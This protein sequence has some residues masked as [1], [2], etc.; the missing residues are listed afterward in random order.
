ME[1]P[2]TLDYI[3]PTIEKYHTIDDLLKNKR[4][5]DLWGM[6]KAISIE[7]VLEESF[8]CVVGEPGV[9]KSRFLKE[10]EQKI[11]ARHQHIKASKVERN[12]F[13]TDIEYCIID[14]LDEV[15][16]ESFYNILEEIKHYKEKNSTIK[17][18]FSCR[19]HY[20]ASY[21]RYFSNCKDL[22]FIEICKLN[23][24]D[25][26]KVVEAQYSETTVQNL[27]KNKKLK[28]LI[29]IPRYLTFLLEY[30]QQDCPKI[31]DLFEHIISSSIKDALKCRN[32]ISNKKNI[33]ILIE[34]VLEK[35]A[36]IM[37]ISRKDQISKDELY[38]ILDGIKGNM[39]QMLIANFDLLFFENRILKLT[40]DQLQFEN[41]ELQEYLSA[42]ELCRQDNIE[43]I[44]YD[45]AVNKEL[46]HIYTNWYDVI[47]HIAYT[48]NGI[49]TFINV[50]K[51]I[52]SY[53]SNLENSSFETLLKY[54]DPYLLSLKEKEELFTILFERY[55]QKPTYINWRGAICDLLQQCYTSNCD[56]LLMLDYNQ[57]NKIQ[58]HNI[59]TIL[60]EIIEDHTLSKSLTNHLTKAAS[61][62]I[63]NKD[64]DKQ[65]A[66]LNFYYTL[67]SVESLTQL[68][69]SYHDFN[70]EVKEKYC[71]VSGY[72]KITDKA[73]VDCW[74][75][76][77]YTSN[78]YAINAIINIKD[79]S[80]LMYAYGNLI[81]KNKLDNFFNS[82]GTLAV[83]YEI[84]IKHQFGIA[85]KGD[86]ESRELIT[87]IISNFVTQHLYTNL[88]EIFPLV[89][90]ILLDKLAGKL[91]IE[92]FNNPWDLEDI[93]RRFDTNL[94]DAE[95]I[96]A[97]DKHLSNIN[98]CQ[99]YK[100]SMLIT[101]TSKI[102]NIEN[103]KDSISEYIKR[104]DKT[105]EQ[106]DKEATKIEKNNVEEQN[107][108]LTKYYESLTDP[109]VTNAYKYEAAYALTTN[110]Q[111]VREKGSEA[112]ITVIKTF[113]SELDLD[114]LQFKRETLTSYTI[115]R[116]IV[117]IPVFVQALS[118]LGYSD[119]LTPYRII[120]AKTLPNIY[121][122]NNY[123]K[124][125]I[126]TTYKSVIGE[127]STEEKKMLVEWWKS[128]DDDFM[129][130]SSDDICSCITEY[131]IDELYYKLDEYIE[132]YIAHQ[133]FEHGLDASKA[134]NV[135][136]N[137]KFGWDI[138]KYKSLFNSLK[139]ESVT[140]IK[141]QCNAIM[142]EKFQDPDAISWRIEF[143]KKNTVKS[144]ND[145]EC[146]RILSNEEAEITS[147]N[148]FMFR[149][150]MNIHNKDLERQMLHLFDYGLELCSNPEMQEY[151]SYLLSQTY[152][153]FINLNN[154]Y[155]FSELRNKVEIHNTTHLSYLAT[156]IMHNSETLYLN[157]SHISI[158]EAIKLYNKCIQESYLNIRN[159]EDLR[160]YFTKIQAE[161]QKEIQDQ[162]IYTLVRPEALSEDFIQRE[163]KNTIINKCCQIGLNAVQIDREVALQDN[164]RTDL[165]I[166]YGLCNPIMIELKL[167]HNKEIRN[168]KERLAYKKKFI[169]YTKATNACLSVFWVFDVHREGSDHSKFE[170][171]V[172]EYKDLCNT[173]VYLTDCKSSSI[174]T[175]LPIKKET[176]KQKTQQKKT[177]KKKK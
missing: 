93:F 119:L 176:S 52:L 30:H 44:L 80:T 113:F 68:S 18:I 116:S 29:R 10:M 109:K 47:P 157:K 50:F 54:V 20:V 14:A 101:L 168:S 62:L 108:R 86:S 97:I 107:Q 110:I 55:Q 24:T 49:H 42:K 77:S 21:A 48:E 136:S 94:V 34:R 125:D 67:N 146:M 69:H 128:R 171:L 147:T 17:V 112:L 13:A 123:D 2:M 162:G 16:G 45:I 139:D 172:T 38:T 1:T 9:G 23:E 39:T 56:K 89:K 88:N 43:S 129:N 158:S 167:L 81:K 164:K 60:E 35:V 90:I 143:L 145:T 36:F 131:G 166:R 4:H 118:N 99:R 103:K 57:L 149:P 92:S 33:E 63:S 82:K 59:S 27:N 135:I 11:T 61:E 141:M 173:S 132:Q 140:G 84:Y 144:P 154:A 152:L 155:Y 133:D 64:N 65:I 120:F 74:L 177:R 169:Q 163:L 170:D 114:N 26:M 105:F 142:I 3:T 28:E 117:K 104:Y 12:P 41:T 98:I 79:L 111:F 96:S 150:F 6:N 8:V 115:S 91:F 15:S 19:K 72:L 37:E 121:F 174:E 126:R 161:V 130:I 106:W 22:I 58:L 148:P 71:E 175:G 32:D 100:D 165:L 76:D 85:W 53:E 153:Y 151:A 51:L 78:P 160:H 124:N 138:D 122:T 5:Y 137:G 75:H 66:G 156:S 159:D 46:Q 95:L 127:L 73:V 134:L 31:E 102:R 25:V 7:D 40:N 70:K 83:F 87:R